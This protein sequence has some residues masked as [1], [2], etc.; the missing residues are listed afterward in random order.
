VF[1]VFIQNMTLL[2]SAVVVYT[3]I[4]RRWDKSSLNY[5]LFSGLLFGLVAILG[6][7]MPF[8]L[9]PGVFFDGRT[10]VLSIAGIFCGPITA[11]IAALISA[12]HRIYIGGAGLEVGVATI[13]LSASFG[14]AYHYLLRRN[15]KLLAPQ[16]LI[17]FSL[18]LHLLVLYLFSLIPGLS[19]TAVI[20]QFAPPILLLY[21]PATVIIAY[22]INLQEKRLEMETK[23]KESELRL[24]KTQEIANIGSWEHDLKAGVLTWSPEVYDIFG[25][26]MASF[27]QNYEQLLDL[28]HPEDRASFDNGFRVSIAKG[29]DYHESDYRIIHQGSGEI[30]YVHERCEHIKS[31]GG[32]IIRSVGMIQDITER[33]LYEIKLQYI[34]LHD[35]LTGL[36][37]RN[38]FEEELVRLDNSRD[39]PITIV[40]ADLDGL[41]LVNDTLGHVKGDEMLIDCAN[42]LKKSLRQSDI[43]ARIGGDEFAAILLRTDAETGETI[44]GRIRDSISSLKQSDSDLPL[45]LSLGMATA[46]SLEDST[47]HEL[48]KTADDYMYRE[49]LY[50]RSSTRNQIVQALMVALSER[51]FIA[52]GHADRVQDL[53]HQLGLKAGLNSR[54]LSDLALLAQVH[55][56]GKVGIPDH[57][58]FKPGPLTENEWATMRMHPEKGYRIAS[59]SPDLAVVAELILK[60]HEHFDGQGYPMGLREEDIPIECRI[61]SIVDAYDAMTNDRPYSKA[62]LKEEAIAEI[63][64]YAGSQFD[65]LLVETFIEIVEYQ[66]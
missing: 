52:E 8:I 6:M 38:F 9:E 20:N 39:Y 29:H 43:L 2:L 16:G 3:I 13:I 51:D 32:E 65:P 64:K 48:L 40:S 26:D 22:V 24:K 41:K 50:R 58:L 62:K 4:I 35:Q 23:L 53:C 30:R 18:I 60:H 27:K 11:V 34:S 17:I 46:I 36:Y 49:K 14:T 37:N 47:L 7:Q 28:I 66:A 55:D 31:T 1:I 57:I 63:K 19:A 59:A 15:K 12:V 61:L 44:C 42:V 45:S 5:S 21:P 33:K 10:V 25:V 54:Q 56:L